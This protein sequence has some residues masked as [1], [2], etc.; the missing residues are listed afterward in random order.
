MKLVG[1]SSPAPASVP[2][3]T[4]EA[5]AQLVMLSL[6]IKKWVERLVAPKVTLDQLE[7]MVPLSLQCKLEVMLWPLAPEGTLLW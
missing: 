3:A 4:T 1:L 6:N 2:A 5:A 7:D